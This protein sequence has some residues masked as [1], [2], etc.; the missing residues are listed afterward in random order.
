MTRHAFR[1]LAL[2]VAALLAFIPV[3]QVNAIAVFDGANYSQNLLTAVRTLEMIANQVQALQNQVVMID[4]MSRNLAPLDYSAL[5][6]IDTALREINRM[7]SAARGIAFEIARTEQLFA[8]FFPKDYADTVTGD[9]LARDA[10]QRWEYAMDALRQTMLVQAQ[11]VH[12]VDAD[13]G[14]LA[15]LIALSQAAVGNL[16]AQQAAN[17]IVALSAKQQL[18]SQELAAAQYRAEAL[19]RARASAAQEQ[20]RALFK[21]FLGDGN[22]YT[23]RQ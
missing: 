11:V 5:A 21:R 22:A 19:E 10:R 17:Q 6:A 14:E 12:N 9:E 16:Q 2:V 4:G 13:T 15:R 3:R 1:L 7:M 18:Q 23:P 20:A 8:R